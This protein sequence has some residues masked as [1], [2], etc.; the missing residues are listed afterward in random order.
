MS[1][2]QKKWIKIKLGSE[3][4]VPNK[5]GLETDTVWEGL[6]QKLRDF[7]TENPMV[8]HLNL[9]DLEVHQSVLATRPVVTDVPNKV[10]RKRW[11]HTV[12]YHRRKQAELVAKFG[13]KVQ[14]VPTAFFVNPSVLREG[15]HPDGFHLVPSATKPYLYMHP[16]LYSAFVRAQ[17]ATELRANFVNDHVNF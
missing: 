4:G 5:N 10:H 17:I 9:F 16:S 6:E 13:Y 1:D 3:P 8:A 2:D 7:E 11:F 12:V 15:R 14:Q